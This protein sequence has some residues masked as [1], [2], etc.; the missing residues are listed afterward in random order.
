MF[1]KSLALPKTNALLVVYSLPVILLLWFI[2]TFSVNVPFWDDWGLVNFFEKIYSGTINF[3]DFFAQH[4]EHRIFFPRIIFA[5]IAFSSKWN[6]KLEN[7]FSFLLALVNFVF[8]YK[9]AASSYNENN[10]ILFHLFNITTCIINFSLIQYEN[11]LWGFQI[12]WL[13]INTCLIIAVFILTVPKNFHPNSRLL[14]ASICCFI[15]SFSSA[16]GLLSWLAVLPSVYLIEGTTKQKKIRFLVWVVLFSFCVAIYFIGYQKPSQHPSIFF[17][18]QQPF[19][20]SEF[21]FTI[22]GSSFYK[23]IFP[24]VVIGLIILFVFLF[25]NVT[26]F[27]NYQSDFI[28]KANPWISLGWFPILFALI[29]TVGRAGMGIEQAAISRYKTVSILLIISCLQLW[30]LC[31]LYKGKDAGKNTYILFSQSFLV[32]LIFIFVFSSTNSIIEVQNSFIQRKAGQ[33]CLEIINFLDKS[34]SNSPGNCLQFIYPEELQILKLS[35]TLQKLQFRDFPQNINFLTK[36]EKFHG[37]ID[38]PSTTKQ[39]LNL[40]RSDTLKLLGWAILPE[41]QEQPPIV[42]LSHGNNRSFFATGLI[43]LTRPD[44]ATALHSSLYKTSGWEANVSLK[45]LPAGET[46]I[47]G[48]VYD[49]KNR[50]FI[51]LNNEPKIKIME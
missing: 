8:L 48:W 37:F 33:N 3:G 45:S 32:F 40:R 51:Q 19:I 34:I 28:N 30:R 22:I 9:I 46:V 2:T 12:A 16:H 13:F 5:I 42:L 17:L 41:Q 10:K 31:I 29:T 26:C 25:F 39:A 49:R 11:W 44:V 23:N 27:K 47:K 7:Y 1:N 38:V 14:L 35:K 43:N 18:L 21:F 15:A 20:T 6:I 50:Q 36:V 4:N 24:P